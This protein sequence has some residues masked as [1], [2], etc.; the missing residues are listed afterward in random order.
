MARGP[1][2]FKQQD[3]TRALKAARAAGVDIQRFEIENGKIVIVTGK[4]DNTDTT[5]TEIN[6]WLAHL[7]TKQQ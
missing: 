5:C 3:L 6:P 1:S 7:G 2:T 4:P